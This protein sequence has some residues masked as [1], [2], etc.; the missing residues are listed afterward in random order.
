MSIN[1]KKPSVMVDIAIFTLHEKTLKV[2]LVKRGIPPFQD[3]WALPGGGVR[4]DQEA[5]IFDKTLED[6][7]KRELLEETG[8]KTHYLE[9]LRTYGSDS[10]DP[11]EWT[12]SVAYFALLPYAAIQVQSGS[13]A[14]DARWWS[15]KDNRVPVQLAF[16]HQQILHDA[17]QRLQAKV[18]YTAIAVHLLPNAFTLTELQRTYEYLL[19]AKLD[20]S[21][22]RR[23]VH[24][25]GI[26]KIIPGQFRE[27]SN[28]PAQLYCFAKKTQKNVFFPRS[29]DRNLG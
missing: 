9:Q 1:Y 17:I 5:S 21:S 28:R 4:V 11:R 12:V 8:A 24:N 15:I 10:R 20:K 29:A 26:V 22:F 6:A 2:L 7:A 3:H 27:G 16:D 25:A 13:D 23:R 14:A 18:E 19:E